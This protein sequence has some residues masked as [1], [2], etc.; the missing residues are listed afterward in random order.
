MVIRLARDRRAAPEEA[1]AWARSIIADGVADRVANDLGLGHASLSSYA[2]DRR[3]ELLR[4]VDGRLVHGCMVP[5]LALSDMER[6]NASG[7]TIQHLPGQ[8]RRSGFV[9]RSAVILVRI[10]PA[11]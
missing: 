9:A 4:Q 11:Q 10:V 2:L 8:P 5:P 3:L 6:V 1:T 7:V